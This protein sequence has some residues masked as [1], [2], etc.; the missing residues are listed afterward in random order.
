MGLLEAISRLL[1]EDDTARIPWHHILTTIEEK[2]RA[3]RKE[4]P[5]QSGA[6]LAFANQCRP[7]LVGMYGLSISPVGYIIQYSCPAGIQT[8]EV[9]PWSDLVPL[10]SYVYTLYVP[11]PD[12]A[13]RDPSVTLADNGD[14]L[15]PPAWNI[16]DGDKVY[17]NCVVKT[18]GDPWHRMT[19][20]AKVGDTPITIKDSYRDVHGSFREGEIYD[21]LHKEGPAP[22]FLRVKKE[23]EVQCAR[24]HPIT[25]TVDRTTRIKT[26]LIMHTYGQPISKCE[27]LIDFLK[28]MY[29]ILEGELCITSPI[30]LVL[31]DLAAHRWAVLERNI[32]HRDISHGNIMVHAEDFEDED[33]ENDVKKE[34]TGEEHRPIFVNGVLTGCV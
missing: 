29:D 6:Y 1:D 20:V 32:I 30:G 24:G 27:S 18:V 9:F 21:I 14:T 31:T 28:C 23:Y 8:S 12:F 4:G 16:R 5:R 13:T 17:E 11:H 26:R 7:D 34:F 33:L 15:G 25:V 10:V 2:G 3:D 22:G 19:W